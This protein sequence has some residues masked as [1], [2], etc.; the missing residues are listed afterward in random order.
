[1]SYRE[2]FLQTYANLPLSLRT[3]FIAVVDDEPVTW[4]AAKLEIEH[5]S[6]EGKK[7]LDILVKTRIIE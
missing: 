6:E 5:D 2:K 7:I 1:M 4:N 3:E